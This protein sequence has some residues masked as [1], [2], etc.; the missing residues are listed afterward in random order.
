DIRL[1]LPAIR[2]LERE[3]VARGP[4]DDARRVGRF[5]LGDAALGDAALGDSAVGETALHDDRDA[6]L[7][8]ALL[9]RLEEVNLG[10]AVGRHLRGDRDEKSLARFGDDVHVAARSTLGRTTAPR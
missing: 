7:H 8:A 9:D 3:P 6:A 4:H 2:T 1:P 5:A 10:D